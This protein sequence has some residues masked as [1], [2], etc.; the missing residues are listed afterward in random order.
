MGWPPLPGDQQDRPELEA[1]IAARWEEYGIGI[2]Y[3][4]DERP[5]LPTM[6]QLSKRLP[7]V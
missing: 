5:E 7:D 1:R 2:R 6:E 3:L 4:D